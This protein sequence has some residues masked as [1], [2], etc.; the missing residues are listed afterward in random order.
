MIGSLRR[1]GC[2]ALGAAFG[3]GAVAATGQAPW[4]MWFLALP[5]F[6]AFFHLVMRTGAGSWMGLFFG[7]GYFG[8]ALSWIVEPFLVEPEVY[9]WMAPFA[10]VLIA[11]GLGLFWAVAAGLGQKG[12]PLGLAAAF[13]GAEMLRGVVLTGF[14]WALPGH[15]WVGTPVD[16]S[17]ALIGA[18]GLTLIT[19]LAAAL[20]VTA[21]R[22]GTA[23]AA[24][25]FGAATAFGLWRL[26][27]PLTA[28][29]DAPVVRIVQPNAAQHL[30]WDPDEAQRF[31]DRSLALTRGELP[32]DIAIWPE[33]AMPYLL[34]RAPNALKSVGAAGGGA[35]VILGAQRTDGGYLGWNSLAVIAPDGSIL[36]TYD[37]HHLVPFGEYLPL[38]DL[39]YELF[40]LRAFAAQTG[41]SYSAGPGPMRID[42]GPRFGSFAPL[43][44]YEAVFPGILNRVPGR[45]DWIVQITN[46][47]WFGTL[48]GPYQH[49][50][51][52]RLRA[53]EQGLPLARAAN[54]GISAM[55]DA[56][57]RV[58][59]A[60]PLGVAGTLDLPLP[61]PL[62][63][64]PYHRWGEWPV[65]LLLAAL[66]LAALMRKR[67]D[68]PLGP[69]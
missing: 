22:L 60:L 59:D 4:G 26:D 8:L 27:R 65:L 41:N 16:Q 32:A 58:V 3:L 48:T 57:G 33:T 2:P 47:A 9:G 6:A 62:P 43:I 68:G 37:K 35:L 36:D 52:A 31:F 69:A 23:A 67:L 39:A 12:G 49:L 34:D 13:T 15:I 11:F 21:P 46:D 61:P 56:R 45:S 5:A 25:L 38:G 54:T 7:I 40:G 42:I 29:A 66:A 1:P 50:A 14:P 63:P 24:L 51:Q 19:L 18:N 30:K 64:T 28:A 53:I 10:L 17:A 20:P 55:I 44:C